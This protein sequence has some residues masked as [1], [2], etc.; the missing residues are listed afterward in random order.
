M[1]P[2]TQ[3]EKNGKPGTAMQPAASWPAALPVL[4]NLPLLL[5]TAGPA[6]YP[7]LALPAGAF[8]VRVQVVRGVGA[9]AAHFRAGRYTSFTLAGGGRSL[10]ASFLLTDLGP[11]G[12]WLAPGALPVFAG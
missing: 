9:V 5:L 3:V 12:P 8:P 10:M 2:K 11:I 1:L 6:A 7:V 4:P